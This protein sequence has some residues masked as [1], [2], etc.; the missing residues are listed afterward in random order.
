MPISLKEHGTSKRKNKKEKKPA[1]EVPAKVAEIVISK[2]LQTSE[3]T[4]KKE[5]DQTLIQ[6]DALELASI[7]PTK[8]A[9]KKLKNVEKE[10]VVVQVRYSIV[11]VIY[12]CSTLS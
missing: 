5:A 1:G 12:Y 10:V 7:E 2:E 6:V 11:N 4:G 8:P 9:Q 3:A